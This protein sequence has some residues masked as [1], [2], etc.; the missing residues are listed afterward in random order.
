MVEVVSR[1]KKFKGGW[2]MSL[3]LSQ[4]FVWS[5]YITSQSLKLAGY[6]QYVAAP[7]KGTKAL[8]GCGCLVASPV[9]SRQLS[10]WE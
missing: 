8:S 5:C 4:K 3:T 1:D 7:R 10:R 6:I 2:L 9:D